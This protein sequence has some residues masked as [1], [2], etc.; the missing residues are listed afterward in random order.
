VGQLLPL[1]LQAPDRAAQKTDGY[2]MNQALLLSPHAEIDCKPQLEIYADDVKCNH[3][4]TIGQLNEEA[5]FYLQSRAIGAD[6]ARSLL[7]F[8]FAS[9]VVGR[10]RIPAVR[11]QLT[12]MLLNRLPGSTGGRI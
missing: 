9:E 1:G 8:A 12:A 3:G 11:D 7:T 10:I 5:L 6:D 4:S 2:Q